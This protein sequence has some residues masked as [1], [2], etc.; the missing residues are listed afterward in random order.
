MRPPTTGG[1][2][3]LEALIALLLFALGLLAAC[4]TLTS[5][6]RACHQALLAGR[7]VDL[8][9]DHV[10]DLHAAGPHTDVDALLAAATRR[11]EHELPQP[12]LDAALEL[13]RVG[14]AFRAV[15][16]P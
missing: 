5:S 10:E 15:E 1:F 12:A 16:Q 6:L 9:A 13:M 8:A 3:L 2:A 14:G 11:A 7:A 4:A